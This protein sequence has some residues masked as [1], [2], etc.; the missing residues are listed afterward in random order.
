MSGGIPT[1]FGA[2][3]ETPACESEAAATARFRSRVSPT[4]ASR[5][6]YHC[7]RT[8]LHDTPFAGKPRNYPLANPSG[9]CVLQVWC[10]QRPA[11]SLT[12]PI[13]YRLGSLF[14]FIDLAFFYYSREPFA[15]GF[16][17]WRSFRFKALDVLMVHSS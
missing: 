10:H 16:S 2:P 13:R 17:R 4:Y 1:L 14:F 9:S 3:L 5:I 7:P 6:F 8:R 12:P 15:Y 11:L